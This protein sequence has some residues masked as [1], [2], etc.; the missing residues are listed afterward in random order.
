MQLRYIFV[1]FFY[2]DVNILEMLCRFD[3][4]WYWWYR[5]YLQFQN[6]SLLDVSGI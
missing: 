5:N 4:Q 1:S 2:L 6:M 3:Y